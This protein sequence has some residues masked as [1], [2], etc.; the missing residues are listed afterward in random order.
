[1]AVTARPRTRSRITAERK[2]EERGT[3]ARREPQ[4]AP[5]REE[6]MWGRWGIELLAI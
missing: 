3:R 4:E 6:G 5:P 1:M 2:A